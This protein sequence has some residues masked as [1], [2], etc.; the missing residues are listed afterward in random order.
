MD[1]SMTYSAD[2]IDFGSVD[3]VG[4]LAQYLNALSLAAA[5]PLPTP[6]A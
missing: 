6:P 2:M 4:V 5:L 3:L 1:L